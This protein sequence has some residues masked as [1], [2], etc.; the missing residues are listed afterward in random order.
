MV[1][2]VAERTK[3]ALLDAA[4]PIVAQRGIE[5]AEFNEIHRLAG[6]R[7]RS[8]VAYHFGDREGLV[9]AIGARRREP[10]NAARNKMLDR[11]E[12]EHRVTISSLADALVRPM[13]RDLASAGG[14]A[15]LIVL[16]EAATRL[17][18]SNSL[19]ADRRYVDRVQRLGA[20]LVRLLA[21]PRGERRRTIGRVILVTPVLLAD[22]GRAIDKGDIS[23]HGAARQVSEIVRFVTMSMMPLGTD[24]VGSE[25]MRSNQRATAP[26]AT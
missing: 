8:A 16:A 13:A 5:G 11:L 20:H 7:N 6:Q 1:D 19:L 22:I 21:G 12:R 26:V 14:R 25:P 3:A 24:T 9:R 23:Q 17:G 10:V 18:A 15:Y 2:D 4:E